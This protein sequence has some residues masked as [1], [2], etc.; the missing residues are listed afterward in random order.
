MVGGFWLFSEVIPCMAIFDV[1]DIG[2]RDLIVRSNGLRQSLIFA[3]CEYLFLGQLHLGVLRPPRT[4]LI[5]GEDLVL[6][7]VSMR[8]RDQMLRVHAMRSIAEVPNV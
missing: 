2:P 1:I 3:D 8:S 5:S 7:V 4:I 6:H